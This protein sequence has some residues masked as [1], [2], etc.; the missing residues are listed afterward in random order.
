MRV[1]LTVLFS[2]VACVTV[3][4]T[5][6]KSSERFTIHIGSRMPPIEAKCFQTGEFQTDEGKRLKVFQCPA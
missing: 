2:L 3:L 1:L 4:A 5:G 6:S